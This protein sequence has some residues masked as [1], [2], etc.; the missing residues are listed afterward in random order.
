MDSID[1]ARADPRP[2]IAT[3]SFSVLLLLGAVFFVVFPWHLVNRAL[4]IW[5][6]AE[7]VF[8]AQKI[9]D[10][11]HQSLW[12][13][14]EALYFERGWRPISF[15]ALSSPFFVITGGR[16][17]LS[18]GL[19]QLCAALI[20]AVYIYRILRLE[21]S[22]NRSVIG[23]L[24]VT[25]TG[26]LV[27]FS[28]SFYSEFV[29]LSL[30]AATSFHVLVAATTGAP[31]QYRL[32]GIWFGLMGTVRPIETVVLGALPALALLAREWNRG[33]V[34]KRDL[35]WFATQL[36]LAGAAVVALIVPQPHIYVAVGCGLVAGGIILVRRAFAKTPILGFF[37]LAEC[38]AFAW[39]IPSIRML[40]LWAHE[41]SFGEM[42]QVMDQSFRGLS[43]LIVFAQLAQRYSPIPLVILFVVALCA[44]S[45]LVK[46][47]VSPFRLPGFSVIAFAVLMLTPMLLLYSL[48]GTSDFRRIMPAML[49]LN[50]GLTSVALSPG[51]VLPHVRTAVV[52][53]LMSAQ[54][55]TASA[56]G[57]AMHTPTLTKVQQLLGPSRWPMTGRDPNVPV[58]DGIVGLGVTR[59]N[60]AAYTY[61]YRDYGTCTQRNIPPFE[62]SALG[63]LARERHLPI[64]VHFAGDLDFSKP[65]SLAEQIA[66]RD[67]QYVLIDM[68]DSPA[69]MNRADP[70]TL[71]T[72]HFIALERGS[73]PSGLD[74]VGCFSTANR[75]ICLLKVHPSNHAI[76]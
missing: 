38:V 2:A 37:V 58:L 72:E 19:V 41:T 74:S 47:R 5:D 43:P 60:I 18:V 31:R 9:A 27:T 30:T 33:A 49:L 62:P 59:G 32:A 26:W 39:N 34:D 63:A 11:F 65:E 76:P 7:F 8:T 66:A 1:R 44:T 56:N 6:E 54:V 57:L 55:A 3:R 28:M 16:I 75:P 52:L 17:L 42:A 46:S 21:L 22:A 71:H 13:G 51:G 50:V 69:V 36:A 73:L 70:Y 4:P 64:G 20:S 29:W 53:L 10:S 68:F 14:I 67:F 61:C 45:G 35:A 12:Q 25:S 48:T 24:L 23:A 40:Y 15:P